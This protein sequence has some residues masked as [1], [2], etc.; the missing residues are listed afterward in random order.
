MDGTEKRNNS[1]SIFMKIFQFSSCSDLVVVEEEG[2]H[3][4]QRCDQHSNRHHEGKIESPSVGGDLLL[5]HPDGG[6]QELV[7]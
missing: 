7:S 4:Q 2:E 3:C 1:V 6:H 5:G